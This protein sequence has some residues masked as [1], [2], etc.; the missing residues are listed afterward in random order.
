[1]RQ[2][3]YVPTRK[4]AVWDVCLAPLISLDVFDCRAFLPAA[5]SCLH[6]FGFGTVAFGPRYNRVAF[7]HHALLFSQRKINTAP[8]RC[9]RV[10]FG[11]QAL[12]PGKTSFRSAWFEHE[13]GRHSG[14]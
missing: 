1:M 6:F 3:A 5:P 10:Q 11:N 4:G 2:L 12:L 8:L 14:H 7:E 9:R 13:S